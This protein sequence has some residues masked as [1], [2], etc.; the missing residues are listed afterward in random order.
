MT[1]DE[2]IKD[3]FPTTRVLLIGDIMLDRYLI[4]EV[5]RIS[6]EAPVPVLKYRR[7]VLRPGGMANVALNLKALG[8][9]VIP[10]SIV[11]QDAHGDALLR[12]LQEEGFDTEGIVSVPNRR[13]TVK[14]R[15]M[16]GSQ[17]LMRVDEEDDEDICESTERVLLEKFYNEI[18]GR[19]P[20]IIVFQD[21]DKGVLAPSFIQKV[22]DKARAESI[23]TVVDPKKRHFFDFAGIDLFKPNLKEVSEA[24]HRKCNTDLQDLQNCSQALFEKLNCKHCLITLSE[25][26]VF[27]SSGDKVH[28]EPVEPREVVDVCGAGDAVLSVVSLAFFHGLEPQVVAKLANIAGGIVCG[29]AGVSPIPKSNWKEE[30]TARFCP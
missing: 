15:V 24:L 2:L 13:T 30:L 7:N 19:K 12:I 3:G 11:G 29:I 5:Q 17:Q 20:D 26:G 21:Y 23:L 1:I 9:N 14:T 8:A 25:K 4:G 6:P 22:I 18:S 10:I 16:A 28:L 27:V